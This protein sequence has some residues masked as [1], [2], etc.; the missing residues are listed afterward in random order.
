MW[1]I[2]DMWHHV[3]IGK[4]MVDGQVD[5]VKSKEPLRG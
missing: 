4:S 5:K 2:G 3:I 1:A